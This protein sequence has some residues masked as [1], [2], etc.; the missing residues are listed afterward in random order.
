MSK[1][2]A[3]PH[4]SA[5]LS[6]MK[7]LQQF[8]S[9]EVIL[10]NRKISKML[11]ADKDKDTVKQYKIEIEYTKTTVEKCDKTWNIDAHT[12]EEAIELAKNAIDDLESKSDYDDLDIDNIEVLDV[13]YPILDTKTLDMFH[14]QNKSTRSC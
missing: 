11:N 3:M 12:E 7:S 5:K 2:E 14:A 4:T 10:A 6:P 8:G 13:D 9:K 1:V